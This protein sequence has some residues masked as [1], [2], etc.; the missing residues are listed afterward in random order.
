MMRARVVTLALLA[1]LVSLPGCGRKGDPIRPAPRASQQPE[2]L[3]APPIPP[4]PTPEDATTPEGE[5]VF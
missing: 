5:E 2:A 1:L 4:G 3:P